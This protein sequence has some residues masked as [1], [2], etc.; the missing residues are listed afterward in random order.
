V[1]LGNDSPLT[2]RGDL[3]D[4]I[5]FAHE[6][7]G[8]NA[9][10]LYRMTTLEAARIL[11]LG[12]GEGR[13]DTGSRADFIAVRD[14]GASPAERLLSLS[15]RDVQLVV[16]GGRVQLASPAIL[17]HLP[18]SI[19]CGLHPLSVED[20]TR[21]LRAPIPLLWEHTQTRRGG[22][23]RMNGRKLSHE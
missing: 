20:Q 6:I 22:D 9:N 3:L 10:S 17:H 11:R 19:S 18:T 2:A 12:N 5:R 23:L 4:E 8:M 7:L 14:T 21:W 15:W 16:I 13:L 1:A